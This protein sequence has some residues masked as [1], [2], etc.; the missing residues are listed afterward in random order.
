M[1]AVEA[2][3]SGEVGN[4]VAIKARSRGDA[5]C[6]CLPDAGDAQVRHALQLIAGRVYRPGQFDQVVDGGAGREPWR[7]PDSVDDQ[8]AII[9]QTR[10]AI[11]AA[12][13][14]GSLEGSAE[15]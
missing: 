12:D 7:R 2:G 5:V 3:G 1:E 9:A 13:F 4:G 14:D 15:G 6:D 11:I 10:V 8:S